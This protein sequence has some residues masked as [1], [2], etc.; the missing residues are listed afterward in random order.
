MKNY[1][2]INFKNY[3]CG[4]S[5]NFLIVRSGLVYTQSTKPFG[6]SFWQQKVKAPYTQR[7]LDRR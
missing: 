7:K 1:N 2:K 6:N 3:K 5:D 4:E